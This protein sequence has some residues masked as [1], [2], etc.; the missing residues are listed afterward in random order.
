M[1]ILREGELDIFSSS[2]EQTGRMGFRLGALLKPGDL[3]CLSGDMGAG[4]T[5][6]SQGIGRGWGSETPL[7]SPTFHLVHQHRRAADRMILYHLDCYRLR[8]PQD[9]DGVGLDDILD[10]QGVVVL[11]WAERIE[12]VLPPE[13]LWVDLRVLDGTRRNF[14]MEAVGKRYEELLLQFREFVYGG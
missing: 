1:P 4:K 10:S 7:T 5:V 6:F 8:G 3:I 12:K 2:A 14:V 9:V 11:E 13:R